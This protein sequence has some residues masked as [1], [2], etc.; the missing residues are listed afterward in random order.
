MK[1]LLAIETSSEQCS[2]A[3][4]QQGKI[5]QRTLV[6]AK[7]HAKIVLPYVDE[8]LQRGQMTLPELDGVIFG[9]GPGSFTGL[10]VA[11]SVAQ[12]L[13]AAT[14]LPVLGVSSL[15]AIAQGAYQTYGHKQVCVLIDARMSEMYYGFY[16]LKDGW[17]QPVTDEKVAK[18][19]ELILLEGI[20]P[21]VGNGYVRYKSELNEQQLAQLIQV[22][23]PF[24]LASD[25][26]P[27]ALNM[28]FTTAEHAL[29]TYV[30]HQVVNQGAKHG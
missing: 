24:P 14:N 19:S 22:D 29:P 23:Y 11:A 9:K 5:I 8:V 16:C 25:L 18:P 3:L 2:V 4:W 27:L 30:R 12:G 26:F 20:W 28:P 10:R 1:H 17:M 7:Q 21:V 13:T 6:G 15:N